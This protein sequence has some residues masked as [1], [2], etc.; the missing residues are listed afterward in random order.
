LPPEVARA[1]ARDMKADFKTKDRN[2]PDEIVGRQRF[3][4]SLYQGPR[5]RALRLTEEVRM[6]EAMKDDV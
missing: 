1:F 6:F 5:D 2:K 4:L 3:A